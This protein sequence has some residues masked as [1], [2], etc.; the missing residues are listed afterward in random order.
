MG[1][2]DSNNEQDSE[3]QLLVRVA[4]HY[5]MEGLTQSEIASALGTNRPRVNRL[6]GE[7]RRSGLVTITLNSHLTACVELEGILCRRFGLDRAI[8]VPTPTKKEAL[9]EILGGAGA[10]L[11][12]QLLNLRTPQRIGVGWGQTVREMVRKMPPFRHPGLS[13]SSV[14]GG[15]TRGIE[16]NTFDIASDL[17]RRIGA[18]CSYFAAPIY[19]SSAE[20]RDAIMNQ[21][22][23]QEASANAAASDVV[24]L[25]VGDMTD[26]SLMVRNGVPRDLPISE[27]IEQGACGDIMGQFIDRQG[28]PVDHPLNA[29]TLALPLADLKG[30][31]NVVLMSGGL[32][33]AEVIAAALVGKHANT[34]ICDE[35][36]A[37]KALELADEVTAQAG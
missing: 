26:R 32:N 8:I 17:A 18:E 19:A 24:F 20:S 35:E 12:T 11:L 25:S 22:V 37:R 15:L 21:N 30:V 23:F 36:T 1:A 34:L 9:A 13:V 6:I 29:R 2:D 7:A 31:K 3:E 33:K 14:M 5:F 4:W 27:L 28:K 16:I 10:E